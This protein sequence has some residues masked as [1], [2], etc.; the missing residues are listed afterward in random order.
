MPRRL[1]STVALL[2][3]AAS[4]VASVPAVAQSFPEPANDPFYQPPV[5]FESLPPGTVLRSRPI[6]AMHLALP[7]PVKAW[8]ILTR[9]N[10]TK[11]RAVGVV[12]TLMVPEA[13]YLGAGPRPLLSY[14]VAINSLGDQCMPSYALRSGSS[15]GNTK[16][17]LNIMQE[18]LV[19][20]WAVV[21]SDHEGPR[22]AYT[23]ARMGGRASLDGIRAAINLSATGLAGAL[24]PIGLMGYSGGAQATGMAA[25]LQ[26]TYAPEL[27][28]K[29]IASG[30]TV[31]DLEAGFRQ[32]DGGPFSGLVFGAMFGLDREYPELKLDRILNPA[33]TALKA[34]I[35]DMCVSQLTNSHPLERF[36][37]YTTVADPFSYPRV[38]RAIAD[39][40]LGQRTPTAPYYLYH[41]IHDELIPIAGADELYSTW[42]A[43]GGN[44]TYHRDP[45][46]DH[47]SLL[48]SGSPAA[49]AFLEDRFAGIAVQG[50]Q[51]SLP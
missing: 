13:P 40:H 8:Q 22:Y 32:L 25:E 6:T 24:T 21:T 15:D 10:D 5:R 44:V 7:L 17:E 41:A 30:G 12:A 23:A 1:L 49:I 20:G 27:N 31:A 14:Q 16:A 47:F 34:Q 29:G 35:A 26:P 4:A 50:C 3:V 48:V 33:G 18:A 46:S 43:T 45:A 36:N 28:I 11:D 42:C 37:T 2:I 51:D 19:R 9:S 38:A 39:V